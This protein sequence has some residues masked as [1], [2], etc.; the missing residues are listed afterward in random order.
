MFLYRV[1]CVPE[2]PRDHVLGYSRCA[3]YCLPCRGLTSVLMCFVRLGIQD[4]G[5][6][7]F[8]GRPRLCPGLLSLRSVLP[9]RQGGDVGFDVFRAF[10]YSGGVF[11]TGRPRLCPGLLSL[12]SVLPSMQGVTSVSMCFVRLGILDSGDFFFTETPRLCPGL[13]SLR[14]VLP[15]RQ[16]GRWFRCVSCVW[17]F[18]IQ[19]T[20][21][22]HRTPETLSRVTLAALGIAFQAGGDVG[23]DVFR[24][25]GYSGFR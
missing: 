11:F 25:F 2:T 19:V 22:F 17:V 9:F 15:F 24:A 7:F 13:L 5:D 4:L 6:F 1:S 3:R 14:S 16:G 21:F 20:F 18:R 23:Y 8:T 10:G 12:R